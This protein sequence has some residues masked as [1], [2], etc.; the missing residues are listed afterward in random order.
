MAL[1]RASPAGP[2]RHRRITAREYFA[3]P[4]TMQ[5][6]DLIDGELIV[7]P[8]PIQNHQY[9]VIR[10]IGAVQ[11]YCDEHGGCAIL[12]PTDVE[13]DK[14]LVLQPDAGY[15][16]PGSAA[17]FVDHVIGPPDLV[18]EVLSPG[19]GRAVHERKMEKCARYGVR[20]AWVVDPIAAATMVYANEAGAWKLAGT[21]AFGSPIPS[22]VVSIGDAGLSA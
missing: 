20:E 3:M 9:I 22:S 14:D 1:R 17:T 18:V 15:I 11:R 19:T 4:E 6:Q 13:L 12:S 10:V 8:A 5:R 21:A 2:R 7:A 16:A